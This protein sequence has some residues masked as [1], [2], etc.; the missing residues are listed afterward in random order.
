MTSQQ[1]YEWVLKNFSGCACCVGRPEQGKPK[2][3]DRTGVHWFARDL[4][5]ILAKNPTRREY[6]SKVRN[7]VKEDLELTLLPHDLFMA[8]APK[9]HLWDR[10]EDAYYLEQID[11]HLVQKDGSP[12]TPGFGLSELVPYDEYLVRDSFPDHKVTLPAKILWR[13]IE[14]ATTELLELHCPEAAKERREAQA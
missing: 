6:G 3:L 11:F 7:L 14:S 4:A 1:A 13:F 10:K 8:F 2:R 12:L 5:D 9:K